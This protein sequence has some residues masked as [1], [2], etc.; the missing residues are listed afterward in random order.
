MVG[1]SQKYSFWALEKW[2]IDFSSKENEH[3]LMQH[4]LPFQDA[5]LCIILDHLNKPCHEYGHKIDHLA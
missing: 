3:F 1:S 5:P 4:C 2:K